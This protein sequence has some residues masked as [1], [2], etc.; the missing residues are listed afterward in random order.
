MKM[1]PVSVKDQAAEDKFLNENLEK[2]YIVSSESSYRFSTF[3]VL[4][5]D[6]DKICYIINY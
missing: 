1:Y 5:K 6:S 4:K 2:G 3:Q